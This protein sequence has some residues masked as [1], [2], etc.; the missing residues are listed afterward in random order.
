[1]VITIIV[2]LAGLSLGALNRARQSARE[3]AT[4][5]T[6]AKLNS[7]I[8]QRYES[9]MT[10][11]VPIQIPAGMPLNVAA[12]YRLYAIRLLM[13]M[14]M[15][16]CLADI[17]MTW[18]ATPGVTITPQVATNTIEITIGSEPLVPLPIPAMQHVY[19]ANPPTTTDEAAQ[20]LYLTISRGSPEA[21]EQFFQ[22]EIGSVPDPATGTNKPV[23]I[24]GWGRPSPGSAGPL[25]SATGRILTHRLLIQWRIRPSRREIPMRTPI[26][27]IPVESM[28]MRGSPARSNSSL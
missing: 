12:R 27:L 23:F 18:P 13:Q 4:K 11:R 10:R 9:Y 6:I 16:D 1:V 8:M 2:T 19:V 17:N 3:S 21:M 26:R 24:D 22:S 15:P 28:W 5:A 25:D 20:C 14:E 7:I